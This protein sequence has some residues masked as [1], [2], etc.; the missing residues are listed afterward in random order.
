MTRQ[1]WISRVSIISLLAVLLG[2]RA[3][4]QAA[5]IA[6]EPLQGHR[7][8]QGIVEQIKDDQLHIN[9]GE[10]QP[11]VIPWKSVRVNGLPDIKV[12]DIIELRFNAQNALV[13]YRIGNACGR[14]G[15][16]DNHTILSGRIA[17]PLVSGHH[18]A[19][20][21]TDDGKEL[22]VEVRTEARSKMGSLPVGIDAVFMLDEAN[23]IVDVNFASEE[24]A[25]RAG[26]VFEDKAP[27]TKAQQNILGIVVKTLASN[28]ITIRTDDGIEQPFEVR[29]S[30]RDRIAILPEGKTVVLMI[31]EA[32][33][34]ADMAVT[35]TP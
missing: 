14:T 1:D 29:P 12:G 24:A 27:L 13:D 10:V 16:H 7:H 8:I 11:R 21:R 3:S 2:V 25:A 33:Q 31:D 30:M 4:S 34:V 35:P 19:L 5:E 26:Q 9:I 15:G 32:N 20:I 22:N 18:T 6:T 23:K 17:E 28:R